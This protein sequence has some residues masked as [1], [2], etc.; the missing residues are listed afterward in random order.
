MK[1]I[2]DAEAFDIMADIQARFI[3]REFVKQI[4]STGLTIYQIRHYK[5]KPIY[6]KYLECA[7]QNLIASSKALCRVTPTKRKASTSPHSLVRMA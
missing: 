5:E 7:K 1:P 6:N 3:G 2:T 4:V